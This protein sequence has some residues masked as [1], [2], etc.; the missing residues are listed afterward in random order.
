MDWAVNKVI[1]KCNP[2]KALCA[3]NA[4]RYLFAVEVNLA[5]ARRDELLAMVCGS[6]KLRRY[7]RCGRIT[8]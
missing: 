6:N 3:L 4:D 2:N 5:Q 7:E 1:P 8:A